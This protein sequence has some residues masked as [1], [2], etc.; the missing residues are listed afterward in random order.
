MTFKTYNKIKV[1]GYEENIDIFTNP[2][3]EIFIEEKVDGCFNYNTKIDTNKGKIPIGEIVNKKLDIKVLSMNLKT[4]EL[5]YKTIKKYYKHGLGE[6]WTKLGYN[7][8]GK[9]KDSVEASANT[10]SL[11][12]ES[13]E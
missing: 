6:N 13:K 5:E 7:Y 9:K 10:G 3:D 2:D 1:L 11:K 4:K 12:K 8:F